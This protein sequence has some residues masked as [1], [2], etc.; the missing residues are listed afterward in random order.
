MVGMGA[1]A[2]QW[3]WAADPKPDPK[4]EQSPYLRFQEKEKGAEL[5]VGI[6]TLENKKTGARV[7]L[8]GAVHIGDQAY[9]EKLNRQFK[10]YDAVLYEMDEDYR[11]RLNNERRAEDR[12]LGASLRRLR[13]QRGLSRDDFPGVSA[14]SIARIER[15]EVEK[16]HAGTLRKVADRLGVA[17]KEIESY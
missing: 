7:D 5:Q 8:V 12:S 4:P 2:A 9:Y 3:A 11:R 1:L 10:K 6:I 14:K 16:P 15:G 17:V 13:L